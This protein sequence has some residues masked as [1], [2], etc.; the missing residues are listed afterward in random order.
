MVVDPVC[1]ESSS[2][3][4]V[5]TLTSSGVVSFKRLDVDLGDYVDLSPSTSLDLTAY[6]WNSS[7]Q[8]NATAI[9]PTTGKLFGVVNLIGGTSYLVQLDL[10]SPAPAVGFVG[11]FSNGEVWAGAF[12]SDGTFAVHDDTAHRLNTLADVSSLPVYEL[13][14]EAP[15]L[16]FTTH[17]TSV[18]DNTGDI[19]TVTL[20]DGSE[21]LVGHDYEANKISVVPANDLDSG[22]L[23]T[24]S[25]P[26][27]FS[28]SN[29]VLGAAWTYA[30]DA[31]F[32]C[33][34][35]EST[36]NQL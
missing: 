19:T 11:E 1:T 4:L 17:A 20:A 13:P 25:F 28:L 27:S 9:D 35:C 21:L 29:D 15:Q 33:S 7:A 12:M 31:Y 18:F 8:I 23:Y 22:S 24:T 16:T 6:G 3:G 34:L 14:T 36:R 30:G 5:Q 10:A 2:V 32:R 26:S